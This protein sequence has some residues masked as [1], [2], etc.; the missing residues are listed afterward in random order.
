MS[1]EG[2]I[3]DKILSED[4]LE[5]NAEKRVSLPDDTAAAEAAE[6]A[7]YYNI[8][9]SS[10]Y[11]SLSKR[12]R[13][14]SAGKGSR[15]RSDAADEKIDEDYDDEEDTEIR[16]RRNSDSD[17]PLKHAS[18]SRGSSL[19]SS[20][21]ILTTASASSSQRSIHENKNNALGEPNR[22]QADMKEPAFHFVGPGS[23]T[24]DFAIE[25]IAAHDLIDT[26]R[27]SGCLRRT[28]TRID[29]HATRLDRVEKLIDR[30]PADYITA[31]QVAESTDRMNLLAKKISS[32]IDDAERT[33]RVEMAKLN[34]EITNVVASVGSLESSIINVEA[35][36]KTLVKALDDMQRQIGQRATVDDLRSLRSQ[37]DAYATKESFNTLEQ[38]VEKC[39]TK[40][41]LD[42]IR[43]V[44]ENGFT[45]RKS[46]QQMTAMQ[47]TLAA[48]IGS[49]KA[50]VANLD[51]HKS[52]IKAQKISEE[53]LNTAKDASGT[54]NSTRRALDD[55][56]KRVQDL[57][58]NVQKVDSRGVVSRRDSVTAESLAD[59]TARLSA[60][61]ATGARLSDQTE[62]L[63]DSVSL[64]ARTIDEHA[65][66]L[67]E[68]ADEMN[69]KLST[70][71]WEQIE[72]EI[73]NVYASKTQVAEAVEPIVK[74]LN[75]IVAKLIDLDQ[76]LT[77]KADN[78][79][80]VENREHIQDLFRVVH[81]QVSRSPASE[82][83]PI[84][85]RV[86]VTIGQS[87]EQEPGPSRTNSAKLDKL[88]QQLTQQG[89]LI[90]QLRE[91]TNG[92]SAVTKEKESLRAM[93]SH[94][95]QEIQSLQVAFEELRV[96]LISGAGQAREKMDLA[97]RPVITTMLPPMQQ[98]KDIASL[99][100]SAA[101]NKPG[102][103]STT[104]AQ[105]AWAEDG[106]SRV[107]SRPSSGAPTASP[108]PRVQAVASTSSDKQKWERSEK[109]RWLAETRVKTP[110]L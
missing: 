67:Q 10:K 48:Q 42:G 87:P 70:E 97:E 28:S 104:D 15:A 18:M 12:G 35:T 86:P 29:Q 72:A 110:E 5:P 52:V 63:S 64:N 31:E 105:E 9:A 76:E 66:M 23:P 51:Q 106:L 90:E 44:L 25:N 16:V 49:I 83:E 24:N 107:P 62:A 65:T 91:A 46:E 22:S 32:L 43:A 53:A 26:S 99:S 54:A 69:K 88:Q 19:A 100:K 71:D 57:D 60:V 38:Q 93:V 58:S 36:H 13:S 4:N 98:T 27:L 21:P 84:P 77:N 79:T 68:I 41:D 11:K 109:E 81:D 1:K 96:F 20:G 73:D 6:R 2:D 102:D 47:D 55:L 33:Q 34:G 75:Q 101:A 61:D 94:Q 50:S 92:S 85:I 95:E 3:P 14:I 17:P 59:L 37:L 7:R 74:K 8:G 108:S 40:H 80:V 103:D 30:F 89:K 56:V 82:R 39:A 45:N 78:Q